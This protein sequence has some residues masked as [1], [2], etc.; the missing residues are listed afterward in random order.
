VELGASN[1]KLIDISGTREHPG[2]KKT[3]LAARV[4]AGERS[5]VA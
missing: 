4:D 1:D 3:E 2:T 5:F